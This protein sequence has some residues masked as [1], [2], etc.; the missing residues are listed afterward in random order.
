MHALKTCQVIKSPEKV[1]MKYFRTKPCLGWVLCPVSSVV[2][3]V[4]RSHA[5]HAGQNGLNGRDGECIY[6]ILKVL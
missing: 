3:A 2:I 5:C 1:F 6:A 4:Y